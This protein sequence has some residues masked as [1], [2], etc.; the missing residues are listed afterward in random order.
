[1]KFGAFVF[2]LGQRKPV[3]VKAPE[4]Q[5]TVIREK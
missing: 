1:M 2:N 3:I 5:N 4:R